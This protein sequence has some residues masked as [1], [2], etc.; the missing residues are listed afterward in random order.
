[1]FSWWFAVVLGVSLTVRLGRSVWPG[2]VT[3]AIAAVPMA[4]SGAFGSTAADVTPTG[5]GDLFYAGAVGVLVPAGAGLALGW[6]MLKRDDEL[7]RK[8]AERERRA[9][10]QRERRVTG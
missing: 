6:R 3:G 7:E 4:L 8:R 9:A 2:C 10:E 1:M 5:L